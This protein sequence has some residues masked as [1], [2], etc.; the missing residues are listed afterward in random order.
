GT[1]AHIGWLGVFGEF[2][3]GDYLMARR[4]ALPAMYPTAIPPHSPTIGSII[5][6]LVWIESPGAWEQ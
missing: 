3:R 2:C 4:N 5:L 6:M 1:H